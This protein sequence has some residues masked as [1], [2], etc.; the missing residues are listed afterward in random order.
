MLASYL[1]QEGDKG[2]GDTIESLNHCP[3]EES[4]ICSS[5]VRVIYESLQ[6][7]YKE[8]FLDIAIFFNNWERHLVTNIFPDIQLNVLEEK[9]LITVSREGK[10]SIHGMIRKW[11]AQISGEERITDVKS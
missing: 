5:I 2:S 4:D 6:E 8:P 11:A 7:A 3:K 10:L 1:R 9:G